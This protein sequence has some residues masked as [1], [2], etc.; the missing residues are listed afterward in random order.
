MRYIPLFIL[1]F[2]GGALA[3]EVRE[4]A[5]SVSG[6]QE[7]PDVSR[8]FVAWINN[9]NVLGFDGRTD[10]IFA[11]DVD[12]HSTE[13]IVEFPFVFW[14]GFDEDSQIYY[15]DLRRN[16]RRGGCLAND[17]KNVVTN[18]LSLKRNIDYSNR[19]LAWQDNFRGNW[20]VVVCDMRDNGNVGGCLTNDS[21]RFVTSDI[22]DQINPSVGAEFIAWE[23]HRLGTADIF[24]FNFR[25]DAEI[26]LVVET[27]R[28]YNP[29]VRG[30]NAFFGDD[31]DGNEEIKRI[32]LHDKLIVNLTNSAFDETNHDVDNGLM[33]YETSIYGGSSIGIKN[34]RR[35]VSTVIRLNDREYH[36]KT[37]DGVVVFESI[38][39]GTSRVYSARC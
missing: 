30:K 31:H 29:V 38:V 20:D 34:L 39:N 25:K 35:N 19:I 27:G 7:R 14:I 4:V 15:C 6:I 13:A 17:V 18:Y 24:G 12:R 23:D 32:F 22:H 21:K 10:T 11:I 33:V 26:P 8:D 16:G 2:V 37:S 28:Q 5:P 9:H 3:C 36:P 1:I